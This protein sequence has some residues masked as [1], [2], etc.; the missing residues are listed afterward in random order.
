MQTKLLAT[1]ITGLFVIVVCFYQTDK[2]TTK[3]RKRDKAKL[4]RRAVPAHGGE[5]RS[6]GKFC[7]RIVALAKRQSWECVAQQ[8]NAWLP[9]LLHTSEKHE[10]G[11][12]MLL[13]FY[14]CRLFPTDVAKTNQPSPSNPFHCILMSSFTAFIY[15]LFRLPPGLLPYS[16]NLGILLL[17]PTIPTH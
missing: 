11:W 7:P 12:Y 4:D 9:L 15:L 8:I 13:S 14:Y 6:R 16:F 17:I 1:M 5:K 2:K 3:W 10:G